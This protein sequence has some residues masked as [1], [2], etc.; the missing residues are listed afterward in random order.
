MFVRTF[1]TYMVAMVAIPD[2][3]A[4]TCTGSPGGA[5]MVGVCFR[6]GSIGVKKLIGIADY[7]RQSGE[8]KDV[9]E[10]FLK[11]FTESRI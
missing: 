10:T 9:V 8:P 3:C 1:T 7:A 4:H 11:L 6:C 5:H 2:I